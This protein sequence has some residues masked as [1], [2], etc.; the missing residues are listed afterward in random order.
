MRK[1]GWKRSE[2]LLKAGLTIVLGISL[3]A[4]AA[5]QTMLHS[6]KAE[7]NVQEEPLLP[8]CT[9]NG[10]DI[11]AVDGQKSVVYQETT[12]ELSN[13]PV[14]TY[15]GIIMMSVKQTICSAGPG[16]SYEYSKG[17][18]RVRLVWQNRVV[19]LHLGEKTMYVNGQKNTLSE[20]PVKVVYPASEKQ[21]I[22]V[23]M[24]QVCKAL[25]FV[26]VWNE[27]RSVLT[28][29]TQKVSFSG[30]VKKTS[31]PYSLKKYA[32]IQYKRSPKVSYKTYTRLV[33][34][35]KDTTN[36]FQ[37]L[38]V[39]RYRSVNKAQFCRYYRYLIEDYCR[40]AGISTKKS[41]LYNKASVFLKAAKK[42]KLDPVYLVCQTFLES[43]Y[44]TSHLASGN[45]IKR[46]AY[47]SFAR[48]KS[49]KFKTKKLKTKRK[50]YN[51]YGIKAYDADPFVGAT[52]YAYYK[53]WTTVNKAIYGAAK[54][55]SGN[56]IHSKYKQN[57]IFKMRFSPNKVT[58]WH[59]YATAPAYAENIGRRMYLMSSCYASNVAF[60]YDLPK[61]KG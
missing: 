10:T 38:R 7:E 30:K 25:G 47:R 40:E 15:N 36:S 53:G 42:Y 24:E 35:A 44:G 5:G 11:G 61:Y 31:Y 1:N 21:G 16:V 41:C 49:G 12:L 18:K 57:T 17:T 32:K 54:Y 8:V 37:Y 20:A 56:Y 34:T 4:G 52:S 26:C 9:K 22:L 45:T 59:Q 50:V 29:Q 13:T 2:K 51:L 33:N 28:L 3:L 19:T 23:P 55:L 60:L 46:I 39:D 14:V 48:T 58:M 43:A 27:D 6:V